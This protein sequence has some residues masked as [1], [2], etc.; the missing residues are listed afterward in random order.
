MNHHAALLS[1]VCFFLFQT[2][3]AAQTNDYAMWFQPGAQITRVRPPLSRI[4]H[5]LTNSQFSTTMVV[6][7][8]STGSGYHAVWPGLE[9]DA[10]SFVF[11]NVISDSKV[12]GEWEFFV[13]YCCP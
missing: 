11:Q 2:L 13:E 5:Y 8:V 9:N 10:D 12:A 4:A 7:R 1:A 3:T 6:P